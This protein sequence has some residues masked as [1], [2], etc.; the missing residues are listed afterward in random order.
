MCRSCACIELHRF[1]HSSR[2][3]LN[4]EWEPKLSGFEYS[5][6]IKASQRH[7]SFHTNNL[8]YVNGYGDP[9]YIETKSVNHKSDMYSFG[10]VLFEV[11]CGRESIIDDKD[12][13]HLVPLA[14]THYREKKLDNI[15]DWDLW[16]QMDS[17]SFEIFAETAYECLNE[18]RSQRPNIDDIVTRLEKTLELQ[19]PIMS[20]PSNEFAHLK[21]PLANII[22]AT[23]NFAEENVISTSDIGKRYK[24]QLLL[25]GELIDITAQRLK[26]ERTDREQLFWMEISMLSSLK[27]K[28]VV[29]LVGF[30]DEDD[31]KIIIIYKNETARGML[32]EYLSDSMSLT[33]VRR[34]E[35]CVG[36][37]H[38]LSY[39]HYDEPRDFSVIHRVIDS[40]R[41]LLNDEWEPKLSAF[42]HSMKIKASQRHH[43]FHTNTLKYVKGYGDPAYLETKRV[44]HKSD[45]YSFGIVM[46]ELLCGRESII[47]SDTNNYLAPLAA[48]RYRE[49]RLD[50]II[51]WDLWKQMDSQSFNIFAEIA[52]DCLNEEQSQ[53]PNID[54]IVTRLE[55]A[56]DYQNAVL[57]L[58]Q[59]MKV[60]DTP[61]LV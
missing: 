40:S 7:Y 46:S 57:R 35:I 8:K 16:K 36:V 1:I 12:D 19:K 25:S 37:A 4:D 15:I 18:E 47:D 23:N 22:S 50:E 20:L 3:L 49:K 53:R 29:S 9:T 58:A 52:Y 42:E 32:V 54:E 45:I 41:V 33:W 21:V 30:C 6:K 2:V 59:N 39:I 55:K 24:G 60:V 44:S 51:D 38:A 5:M 17:Q 48:T 27:H 26:K 61:F 13:N 56:L 10:I 28:N 11:L 31:D 34:L 43:S 14:I